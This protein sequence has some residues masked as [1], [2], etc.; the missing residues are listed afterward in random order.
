MTDSQHAEIHC[1][2]LDNGRE[3]L[4]ES[5]DAMP[6]DESVLGCGVVNSRK[7]SNRVKGEEEKDVSKFGRYRVW[8][9]E[10]R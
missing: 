8:L 6:R 5:R 9:D 1:C 7:E 3:E 4:A 10:T 2:T